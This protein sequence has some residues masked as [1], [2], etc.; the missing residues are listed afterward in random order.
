MPCFSGQE[1]QYT[2]RLTLGT[3]LQNT[4]LHEQYY[5][6]VTCVVGNWLALF[7][8]GSCT[9]QV[10]TSAGGLGSCIYVHT[11]LVLR[12]CASFSDLCVYS[13]CVLKWFV[14]ST[15]DNCEF[16]LTYSGLRLLLL[17]CLP[18]WLVTSTLQCILLHH[19][20]SGYEWIISDSLKVRWFLISLAL[21]CT[22]FILQLTIHILCWW[23]V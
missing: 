14:S 1:N 20:M 10:W 23:I 19:K 16:V 21:S 8:I 5:P 11:W 4:S 13:R 3:E 12:T 7:S 6:T 17:C 18:H 22:E 2:L 9:V 15:C